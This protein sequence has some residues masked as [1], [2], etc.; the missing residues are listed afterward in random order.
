M[1]FD[2]ILSTQ[3]TDG[4]QIRYDRICTLCGKSVSFVEIDRAYQSPEDI[5][6]IV[7]DD[8]LQLPAAERNEIPVLAFVPFTDRIR[9]NHAV[10]LR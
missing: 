3:T 2:F 7:T 1:T 6:A 4:G 9:R 5:Q 10:D 8:H